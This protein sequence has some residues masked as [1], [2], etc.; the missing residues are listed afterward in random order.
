MAGMWM[1]CR[2]VS[3]H[4]GQEWQVRTKVGRATRYRRPSSLMTASLTN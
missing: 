1:Q 3:S 4:V 2:R